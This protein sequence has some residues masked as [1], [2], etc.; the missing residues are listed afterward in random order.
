MSLP[1]PKSKYGYSQKEVEIICQERNIKIKDFWRAFGVKTVIVEEGEN[2]YFI[3]D[4]E[5]TL[6]KL[7][8]KDGKFHL[9]D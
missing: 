7:N 1:K 9:R 5:R 2:R 6:Y 8:C 3:C 4:I